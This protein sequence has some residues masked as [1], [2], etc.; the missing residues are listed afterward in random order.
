LPPPL[1]PAL[2]V[3]YGY[4]FVAVTTFH[5]LLYDLR[6]YTYSANEIFLFFRLRARCMVIRFA[7]KIKI[8]VKAIKFLQCSGWC[9]F[10]DQWNT[11][12]W[13]ACWLDP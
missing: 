2:L 1:N 12:L 10:T 6:F 4:F 9:G 5:W 7:R 8:N 11:H 13:L 3:T